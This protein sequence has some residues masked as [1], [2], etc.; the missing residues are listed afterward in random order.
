MRSLILKSTVQRSLLFFISLLC[1]MIYSS[2]VLAQVSDSHTLVIK[3]HDDK[4]FKGTMRVAIFDK[5]ENFL[6]SDAIA[7]VNCN[8]SLSNEQEIR[9][10]LPFGQ[11]ALCFFNDQNENGV[12]DTGLFNIPA[13]PYGFSN[14]VIGTFGPPRFAR[15]VFEFRSSE[16]TIIINSR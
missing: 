1:A 13:E 9:V 6:S 10:K 4:A 8:A 11:Y 16:Q 3:L 15:S 7:E 12:L 14:N 2:S 5:E